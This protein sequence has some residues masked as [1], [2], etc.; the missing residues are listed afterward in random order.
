LAGET[1]AEVA[2]TVAD[3]I[4]ADP[5]LSTTGVLAFASES[6]VISNHVI[7]DR[8]V[9][10]LG[11]KPRFGGLGDLP[12]GE[13]SSAARAVSADGAVVVG[14]SDSGGKSDEAFRWEAG[15]M[16]GLGG[17]Q[18]AGSGGACT[19]MSPPL[20]PCASVAEDVSADGSVVVGWSGSFPFRW[21]DGVMAHIPCDRRL[22]APDG[23]STGYA[24]AVSDDGSVVVGEPA[25][26]WTGAD[27]CEFLGT[28]S[29]SESARSSAEGVSADG[30]VI[31]GQ[32]DSELGPIVN[33]PGCVAL[34]EVREAFRWE[35]NGCDP[36]GL[37]NPCMVGLGDLPGGAIQSLATDVSAD[38]SVVVGASQ[39]DLCNEAF[40]WDWEDGVMKGLGTLPSLG[41]T[42]IALA[43]SADG[44]VIVGYVGA[45]S[46]FGPSVGAFI[47]DETHGMRS[48]RGVL[49]DDFALDLTGWTLTSATGV[50]ADG[51][52]IVGEGINPDGF[53][54]GWIAV[55]PVPEPAMEW[56]GAAA[57]MSL[58]YFARRRRHAASLRPSQRN[59]GPSEVR[60]WARGLP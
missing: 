6:T 55:L 50:S 2:A 35:V 48:L 47:W 18:A 58:A 43:V 14:R 40:R 3:A 54:E 51:S 17:F 45:S 25:F 19:A 30:W 46:I 52:T 41:I 33:P 42:S 39:S 57:I 23:P 38:G 60:C 27:G 20:F 26:S 34:R 24:F 5:S 59:P 28:L 10:D 56:L 7:S 31:V 53:N 49:V 37:D 1:A 8:R 9:D 36:D 29:V 13:F 16:T 32:S 22:G 12:G 4:N 11:L 21:E 15:V 44:S